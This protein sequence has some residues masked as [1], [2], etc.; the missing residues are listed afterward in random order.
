MRSAALAIE[1]APGTG[2]RGPEAGAAAPSRRET[3]RQAGYSGRQDGPERR[4]R[5]FQEPEV[6]REH[7]VPLIEG[8]VLVA[9]DGLDFRGVVPVQVIRSQVVGEELLARHGEPHRS[10]GSFEHGLDAYLASVRGAAGYEAGPTPHLSRAAEVLDRRDQGGSRVGVVDDLA[11]RRERHVVDN[12][13]HAQDGAQADVARHH[14]R[15]L[16]PRVRVDR[17]G[18]V[19]DTDPDADA[20]VP[21]PQPL[22]ARPGTRR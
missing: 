10:E 20:A 22:R 18:R 21:P 15:G 12:P 5:G 4:D 3:R 17:V 1:W 11:A 19:A 14:R 6:S 2:S 8:M 13:Y 7:L 16:D 9:E